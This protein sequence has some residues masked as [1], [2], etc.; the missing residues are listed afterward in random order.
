MKD[1]MRVM[2]VDDHG[3]MRAGLRALIER[4]P[5]MEVVAE[6]GTGEDA[7]ERAREIPL[8]VVIMDVG[9]PK[10]SGVDAIKRI[11]E[12]SP[13]TR[14]LA[15]TMYEDEPLVRSVIAAGGKGYVVKS[16]LGDELISAV[17]AVSQGRFHI[18]SSLS[19]GEF[20][21][22]LDGGSGGSASGRG[23]PAE[24]L[25]AREKQVLELL[26]QGYTNQEIGRTLKISP[27]TV[28]TYRFHI[29][30]KLGLNTRADIVRY[31]LESGLLKPR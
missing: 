4:Q 11:L 8:D 26:A 5:D 23:A 27:G 13:K 24:K 9:L 28:G 15:L 14:V 31:A 29:Y 20:N 19:T 1:K 3:V 18:T 7:V 21:S 12:I 22:F 30:E 10:M 2:I 17:R 16:A 6:A 25:S